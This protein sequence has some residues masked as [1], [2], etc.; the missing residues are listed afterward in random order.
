MAEKRRDVDREDI[1]AAI[2][3]TGITCEALALEH[4]FCRSAVRVALMRSWPAV[5]AVIARHIGRRPQDLWPS[6]YDTAG[7]PLRRRHRAAS[8]EITG[9]HVREPHQK[10]HAA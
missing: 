4:G 6:R 7:L 10:A 9:R 1:K 8:A 2:R 5:E 3:K